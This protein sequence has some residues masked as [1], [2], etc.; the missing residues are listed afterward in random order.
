MIAALVELPL[1][2]VGF[3]LSAYVLS[4]YS[5]VLM[6][7]KKGNSLYGP[8]NPFTFGTSFGI[9]TTPTTTRR[10]TGTTTQAT[11][12]A[13]TTTDLFGTGTTDL[14]GTDT[15]DLFG[16]ATYDPFSVDTSGLFDPF[17]TD[18]SNP[19]LTDSDYSA[20]LSQYSDLFGGSSPTIGALGSSNRRAVAT[21]APVAPHR[22]RQRSTVALE[23][24]ISIATSA[25]QLKSRLS[26]VLAFLALLMVCFLGWLIVIPLFLFL[27]HK[28][29]SD[30]SFGR[31]N[32]YDSTQAHTVPTGPSARTTS[33]LKMFTLVSGVLLALT[34]LVGIISF[35][36]QGAFFSVAGG[37]AAALVAF[38]VLSLVVGA[39][40]VVLLVLELCN[41][42]SAD[43]NIVYGGTEAKNTTADGPNYDGTA[44]AYTYAS[45]THDANVADQYSEHHEAASVPNPVYGQHAG[46]GAANSADYGHQQHPEALQA[47]GFQPQSASTY[48]DNTAT[49]GYPSYPEQ[50]GQLYETYQHDAGT[51]AQHHEHE[52]ANTHYAVGQFISRDGSA[53]AP[54]PSSDGPKRKASLRKSVPSVEADD[55][56]SAA[57]GQ[58]G[59][60]SASAAQP[61]TV[62][63][64]EGATYRAVPDGKGGMTLQ[65]V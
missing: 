17:T 38:W 7:V 26:A 35:A 23:K 1:V 21:P 45:P 24:R 6:D 49:N 13:A 4:G 2:I 46:A 15:S 47:G 16:T 5:Q 41:N 30:D 50:Q 58:A 60:T 57:Q 42:K 54:S 39:A 29:S 3:S 34:V 22:R 20:L 12:S 11:T 19:F 59:Q 61:G 25:S 31:P 62:N 9:S 53:A 63:V 48:P 8:Q 55:S 64:V 18:Y 28:R 33:V 36:L 43:D 65:Q 37:A 44:G 51:A 56:Q 52:A 14:F 27:H 40:T 10:Q 32:V